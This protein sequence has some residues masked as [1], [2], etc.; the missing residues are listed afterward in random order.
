MRLAVRVAS[1]TLRAREG[2]TKGFEGE[3]RGREIT[4]KTYGFVGV[5]H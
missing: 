1:M 4:W 5:K 3:K 2:D